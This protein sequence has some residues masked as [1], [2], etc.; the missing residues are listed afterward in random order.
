MGPLAHAQ[1]GSQD[2]ECRVSQVL[3]PLTVGVAFPGG[4]WGIP[5]PSQRPLPVSPGA[6]I[7]DQ[8]LSPAVN[9]A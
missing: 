9:R 7:Q 5:G 3:E 4:R 2:S 1:F 8:V 6:V